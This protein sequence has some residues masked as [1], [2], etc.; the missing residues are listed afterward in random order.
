MGDKGTL[1]RECGKLNFRKLEQTVSAH[2]AGEAP[3][4]LTKSELV[5]IPVPEALRGAPGIWANIAEAVNNGAPLIAPGADAWA[6]VEFANAITISHFT[7]APV[8]FPVD[9]NAYDELLNDLI[10]HKKGL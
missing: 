3:F 8:T 5:E 2:L 9:R 4:P 1:I 7:K 6:A 10:N